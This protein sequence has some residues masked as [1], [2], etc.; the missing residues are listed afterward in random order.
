MIVDLRS[1]SVTRPSAEMQRVMYQIELGDDVLGDDRTVQALEE[2]TAT[3]VQK[4]AA[5]FVPSGT[6]A[7]LIAILVHCQRGDEI[8]LGSEA[9][10][11][12]Y[13]LA[14]P[15]ALAGV[16]ARLIPNLP[17]GS[18]PMELLSQSFRASGPLFPP[19][20]LVCLE[21]TQNRCSG[22]P[23][24]IVHTQ[25]V[26]DIAHAR[27]AALHLDGARIFNAA[28]ALNCR[29]EDLVAPADSVAF[30]L[31]K[32]LGAPSGAMLCGSTTF[33]RHARRWRKTLGG[34]MHM[35][36]MLAAAGLYALQHMIERLQED[37]ENARRLA[38]GLAGLPAIHVD[39]ESVHT[40]IVI[41]QLKD[42]KITVHDFLAQLEARGVLALAFGSRAIRLVTHK[43]IG[44]VHIERAITVF[45]SIVSTPVF[46]PPAFSRGTEQPPGGT[47][48]SL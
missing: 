21:N 23:I 10:I 46:S 30:S 20:T 43:D 32:G 42:E 37:H 35:P 17:D 41:V 13:E 34:A 1:D 2:Y 33:I 31:C 36:G 22:A 12:H 48:V 5:L 7:N 25:Q 39:S 16:Q 18:L 11:F 4:E 27:G 6:Q 40:N 24:D 14:G 8:I 15:A 9:H 44:Q 29:I 38:E 45:Q 26:A 28:V 3:L 47:R 19:I